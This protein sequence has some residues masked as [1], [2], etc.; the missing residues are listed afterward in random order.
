MFASDIHLSDYPRYN[1]HPNQ[2]LNSFIELAK[3]IVEIGKARKITTLIIGGDIVDKN[4]LSP[5]ELHTLFKMFTVLA[6]HFRVYSIIGNHDAKS[7]KDIL[8]QDTAVTLLQEIPGIT[9]HHKEIIDIGGRTIAFE[10]WVPEYDLSWIK[11]PVDLYISHATID[12]DGKG[13]YGMDTSVFDNKFKFGLF[14]D[15][16]VT[17]QIGNLISIGNTKQESLSDT[18]QGGVLV[19]DLAT[20]NYER[21]PIDPEHKKY[22]HLKT[23]DVSE[24]EGWEDFEGESMIYKIFKPTSVSSGGSGR[25]FTVPQVT[26]IEVKTNSIIKESNLLPIHT[27]IKSK[28][29]YTPVDFNFS[30]V[31]LELENYRSIKNYRWD[32]R[33]DYVIN[34]HNGSGKSSL[35][36]GLFHALVGKRSFK[37]DVKFGEQEC[38]LKVRLEYQGILY[39]IKRGSASGYYGLKVGNNTLK[40]NSKLE[41]EKEVLNRLPFLNYHESF[42]FNYS[43]GSILSSFN[44]DRRYDL[45][46]KYYRLDSLNAYNS[47]GLV[48]LKAL[49]KEV[50]DLESEV[51]SLTFLKNSRELDFTN[52][53]KL[54][55][56]KTPEKELEVILKDQENVSTLIKD[57]NSINSKC[58]EIKGVIDDYKEKLSSKKSLILSLKSNLEFPL[59]GEEIKIRIES[60][61]KSDE[62]KS[63]ITKGETYL[64][65]SKVLKES[66]L[67][68]IDL[69]KEKLKNL[70]TSEMKEI[71]VDLESNIESLTRRIE[72]LKVEKSNSYSYLNTRIKDSKDK[73]QKIHSD[74]DKVK[75]NIQ[76]KE[77]CDSCGQEISK[78]NLIST[79]TDILKSE[80]DTLVSFEKKLKDL[81]SSY[82]SHT[83]TIEDLE[84]QKEAFKTEFNDLIKSNLQYQKNKLERI[85]LENDLRGKEKY[86][87]EC[88][89]NIQHFSSMLEDIK[90]DL[91][92][93]PEISDT[94]YI[95]LNSDLRNL[96]LIQTTEEEL[97]D[98]NLNIKPLISSKESELRKLEEKRALQQK[99][100]DNCKVLSEAELNSYK[101]LK[102]KYETLKDLESKYTSSL[103]SLGTKTKDLEVLKKKEA[104]YDLYC[105]LTS[106][107]G[108]ILKSILEDLTRTFSSPKFK[109]VTNRVQS[110]GK[111]VSDMSVDM[112]VD[113]K[114]VPYESLSD[115]QKC[116]CDLFYLTKI[117]TGVG[118]VALD[119]TLKALDDENLKYATSLI[120]GI[121]RKTLLLSSHSPNLSM[122]GTK[123]L[124]CTLVKNT[125]SIK[126]VV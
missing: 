86:I 91:S 83:K 93:L 82:F 96:T 26:D 117:V 28:S 32:L 92:K 2:R 39:E 59:S 52:L 71:P 47:T 105:E 95:S 68:K 124:H 108:L 77:Y 103:L 114:W 102:Y 57:L 53:S 69:I 35:L 118:L 24:E 9:F 113:S 72:K 78:E 120:D 84:S 98:L 46:V 19:M 100:I 51:E 73:I 18:Y 125:T 42:F 15:I 1:K 109:F 62:L 50:K 88:D 54:L 7:K 5:L 97:E 79:L 67:S 111:I 12:Y 30:I 6:S 90:L 119:E 31:D 40:F 110:S 48:E 10:N 101:D 75:K 70:G 8:T 11:S 85:E 60:K 45:L 37:A 17:R 58:Y 94:E 41:F 66:S 76:E 64:N 115:G 104:E 55:E 80:E 22:L 16:H 61:K 126:L 123:T 74:I 121:K 23:T 116:L 63:R 34:G 4:T 87:K 65:E 107:S 99:Y 36:K 27:L 25:V 81:N 29:T 33:S 49:K 106:K 89:T 56:K 44:I 20:F 122:E 3:D 38:K 13:F 21:I 43:D 112:L 14:G